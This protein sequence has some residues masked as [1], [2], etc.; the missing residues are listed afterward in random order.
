MIF[1]LQR[2]GGHSGSRDGKNGNYVSAGDDVFWVGT[3]LFG[4]IWIWIWKK[5]SQQ[6]IT[7]LKETITDQKKGP[8]SGYNTFSYLL[9]KKHFEGYTS[10]CAKNNLK[11]VFFEP[12][13][14]K[15][16]S[17]W[18][19]N[20]SKGVKNGYFRKIQTIFL[21]KRA[22]K[23]SKFL[24]YFLCGRSTFFF[25]TFGGFFVKNFV[26]TVV[27]KIDFRIFQPPFWGEFLQ[28]NFWSMSFSKEK[29]HKILLFLYVG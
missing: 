11:R 15:I 22:Q 10:V 21:Q 18:A 29:L 16:G 9:K 4:A 26:L 5:H 14:S 24:A 8:R 2:P 13:I 12:K 19:L 28:K 3:L 17:K 23:Y 20:G 6:E 27:R 25:I 1:D 7:H